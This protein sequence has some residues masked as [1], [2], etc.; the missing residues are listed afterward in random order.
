MT[1]RNERWWH[2]P[3]Y[4]LASGVVAYVTG[5]LLHKSSS[6]A[7]IFATVFAGVGLLVRGWAFH[8]GR[9]RRV[10]DKPE[11]LPPYGPPPIG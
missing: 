4:A 1:E 5:L 11:N 9:P 2:L 8:R 7:A 6:D 3:L 10:T